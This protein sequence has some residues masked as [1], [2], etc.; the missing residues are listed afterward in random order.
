MERSRVV[1]EEM[2]MLYR[3]MNSH[4][5]VVYVGMTDLLSITDDHISKL[6]TMFRL[7]GDP[8]RLRIILACLKQPTCVSDI[9]A[10]TRLSPSLVSHHLRLLRAARIL[11][12]ERHG[13][14]VFYAPTDDHVRCTIAAMIVHV[15][16]DG[17]TWE[18][19]RHRVRS[20][21]IRATS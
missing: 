19:R 4:S 20:G 9:A 13:R 7:I 18:A 11:R 12:A 2:V 21:K 8:S 3:H 5:D 17:E 10:R 16:E 15:A 6:A 14:Q 1:D